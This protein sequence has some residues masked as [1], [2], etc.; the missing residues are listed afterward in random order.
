MGFRLQKKD[1]YN[2]VMEGI[3]CIHHLT[4]WVN[5]MERKTTY[6]TIVFTKINHGANNTHKKANLESLMWKI[7]T[8]TWAIL[9]SITIRTWNFRTGKRKVISLLTTFMLFP[10][11]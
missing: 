4:I 10:Q 2:K 8:K 5:M 9:I 11:E 1:K 3:S 7:L 6:K